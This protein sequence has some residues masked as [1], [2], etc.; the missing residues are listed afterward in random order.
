MEKVN[1]NAVLTS[2]ENE[3]LE[4]IYKG[5][6]FK[7]NPENYEGLTWE[8]LNEELGFPYKNGESFRSAVKHFQR[9]LRE[10]DGRVKHKYAL[11]LAKGYSEKIIELKKERVKLSSLRN[12]VNRQIRES[13]RS[14]LLIEEF[15]RAAKDNSYYQP[16]FERLKKQKE[17]TEYVLA[18]G[19]VHFGKTFKSMTNEYSIEIA[20][21]RFEDLYNEICELVEENDVSL[22]H[23]I[24]TGDSVEGM[25]LRVSQLQSLQIGLTDQVMQFSKLLINWL[26]RVSEVV[27]INY[28]GVKASNHSQTRPF[29]SKPNEF[30]MEDMERMIN[31]HLKLAFEGNKDSRVKIIESEDR[32]LS[33]NLLGY[34]IILLH[35]HEVKDYDK[36]LKDIAWK[37]RKFFDYAFVGHRH[38]SG[39]IPSGEGDTNNCE[40]IRVPSIMGSDE[41]ADQLMLGS[42]AEPLSILC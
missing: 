36:L 7:N 22:L 24:N 33:L 8:L 16:K 2:S 34:D 19:D 1:K 11:P 27:K 20:E 39:T 14:E 5:I 6:D 30:T 35:G 9:S 42:K 38:S 4:I 25:H 41:Y 23:I 18:F 17:D 40:V 12:D 37:H 15:I 26:K 28:Y 31:Y 3:R 13:S 29:N 32:F 10:P 21:K